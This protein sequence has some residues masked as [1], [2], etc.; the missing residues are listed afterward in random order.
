MEGDANAWMTLEGIEHRQVGLLVGLGDDPAEVADGLVVVKRE[1]ERDATGQPVPRRAGG[2]AAIERERL[3][4][5]VLTLRS[6]VW[7]GA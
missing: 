7:Y 6:L 4:S 2:T 1:G 3:D 5:T